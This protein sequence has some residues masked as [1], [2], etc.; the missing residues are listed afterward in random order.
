MFANLA[1]L[2]L[3]FVPQPRPGIPLC[4]ARVSSCGQPR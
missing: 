4:P 3:A 2:S 1:L